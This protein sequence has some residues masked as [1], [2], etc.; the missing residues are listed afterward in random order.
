MNSPLR[1]MIVDDMPVHRVLLR[2]LIEKEPTLRLVGEANGVDAALEII[3]REQPQV[4]FLDVQMPEKDG[5]SLLTHLVNPP[6]VVF[7]SAWPAFAL[8]AFSVDAVDYL[9]KPVEPARFEATVQ[10]L[11]RQF[12]PGEPAIVPHTSDDRICLRTTESTVIVPVQKIISLQASGDFSEVQIADQAPA[13]VCRR[14]G[15]FDDLLPSPPFSR[16]DRSLI[17]NLKRVLRASWITRDLM[18]VQMRGATKPLELGR[19]AGQRL[20]SQLP[21]EVPA[22]N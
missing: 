7:V 13:F 3:Q 5:F 9:L 16:L 15:D 18:E 1:V 22:E 21:S 14:L 2:K 10:R 11:L 20:R 6:K 8:Q 19:T 12:Q 4:V 17:V